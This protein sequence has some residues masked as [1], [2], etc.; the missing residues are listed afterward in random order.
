MAEVKYEFTD[1]QTETPAPVEETA[2]PKQDEVEQ[3]TEP[4]AEETPET[5]QDT[6]EEPTEPATEEE[7]AEPEQPAEPEEDDDEVLLEKLRKRGFKGDSLEELLQDK[8]EKKSRPSNVDE[9][10]QKFLDYQERTGRGLSDYRMLNTDLSEMDPVEIARDRIIR[11]SEGA[12][13]TDAEVN[14]LLE[15]ELGFDPSE[16]DLDEKEQAKFKRFYGRHLNTLKKEQEK[17]NDPADGYTPNDADEASQP[18]GEKVKLSNGVE[19]DAETYEKD[20]QK[21]LSDRDSALKSIGEENFKVSYDGKDGKKELDLSYKY[22]EEDL[23]RMRSIT[24]DLGSIVSD[25][26]AESGDFNHADFNR[27][28]VWMKKDFR[29]KAF[30][31]LASRVRN[32][33]IAE[34][35]ANRKNLKFD[36]PNE[37]PQSKKQGYTDVGKQVESSRYGVK[38]NLPTD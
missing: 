38:Y 20:R 3:P 14:S 28:A 10:T 33:V 19:V 18:S 9:E 37:P 4:A 25:Y 13:L 21:Y 6:P 23:Q 36:S 5:P 11:E 15:D 8:E 29:D 27:D 16:D 26:Q 30:G 31:A 34:M 17:Y 24:D 7:G 32:E 22:S 1:D 12:D 35:T 2:E